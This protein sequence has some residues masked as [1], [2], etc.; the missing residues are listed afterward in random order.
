MKFEVEEVLSWLS[1]K[2][3]NFEV[4]E[5]WSWRNLK[6]K[7]FEVEEICGWRSLKLMFVAFVSLFGLYRYFWRVW[8]GSKSFS[9]LLIQTSNFGFGKITVW[10]F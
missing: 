10:F 5:F 9:A 3:K 4:K 1:L 6:F 7:K 2:L 8:V